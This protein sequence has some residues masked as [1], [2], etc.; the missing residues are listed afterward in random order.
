MNP[1]SEHQTQTQINTEVKEAEAAGVPPP[2][3]AAP[4]KMADSVMDFLF[5]A[6]VR[7]LV[8]SGQIRSDQI[9]S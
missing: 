1:K 9:R 5:A 8:R 4:D 6:Q 3:Y 7:D 2:H